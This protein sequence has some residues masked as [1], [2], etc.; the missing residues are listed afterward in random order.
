[1]NIFDVP[2]NEDGKIIDFLTEAALEPKPE[3][4]VR[5]HY[6]RTLHYEF[7][8]PKNVLAREVPIYYG[9]KEVVDKE[10]NPVRA[11]IVVYSSAKACSERDQGKFELI[12]ECKAPSEK[13]GYNQL[14][15]YVFNTSANG[16]VWFNGRVKYYRR[17]STPKNELIDWI[18]IPRKG[19]A[20]DS[21]GRRKKADL[22]RPK[23]IKGLLR[24]CHNKGPRIKTENI[25]V[26]APG[27]GI[28][29]IIRWL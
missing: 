2:L 7:Q 23:D 11:D 5:Q 9:R 10:G 8:Y 1:M 25:I 14:V 3:E 16:A 12:V 24:L 18:G 6:L 17:L 20:W 13:D 26:E 22:I 21:L 28:P 29:S 4:F 27:E 15:S 19:E